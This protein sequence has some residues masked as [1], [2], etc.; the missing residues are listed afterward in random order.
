[1]VNPF[2]T[3]DKYGEANGVCT[4]EIGLCLNVDDSRLFDKKTLEPVCTPTATDLFQLKKPRPNS[5]K[6]HEVEAAEAL[7]AAVMELDVQATIGGRRLNEVT[8]SGLGYDNGDACTNTFQ[9]EVPLNGRSK[10]K[11]KVKAGVETVASETLRA[12]RD[13]DTLKFTCYSSE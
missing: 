7:L 4:F 10:A 11:G 8:F 9:L 2:N 6:L 12:T 13:K 3:E 1:V 5:R